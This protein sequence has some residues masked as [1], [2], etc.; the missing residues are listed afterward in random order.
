M[1]QT[2]TWRLV[3]II[4]VAL[5]ALFVALD[6]NL[7]EGIDANKRPGFT[8][9]AGSKVYLSDIFILLLESFGYHT[10]PFYTINK[11]MEK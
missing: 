1:S 9:N 2:K 3:A 6:I 8:A 11:I 10:R 7:V 5:I 4:L